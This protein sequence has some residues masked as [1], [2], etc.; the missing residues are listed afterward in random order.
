MM[1]Q[2]II[3]VIFFMALIILMIIACEQQPGEPD[4]INIFDPKNVHTGGDPFDLTAWIANGGVTLKWNRISAPDLLNYKIYRSEQESADL[5]EIAS[6]NPT[7]TLYID[8]SVTNGHSY[9]YRVTAVNSVGIETNRSKIAAVQIN[10]DPVLLINSGE[11]YS[12]THQVTLTILA[13]SAQ[14]MLLSNRYDFQDATWEEYSTEKTWQLETGEGEREVYLKIRY[15]DDAESSMISAQIIVDIT[16]PTLYIA[17]TP[18]SGIT[19]ETPFGFDPLLSSDNLT[20]RDD[21]HV[22]FDWENDGIWDESWKPVAIIYHIYTVGGGEKTVHIEFRDEAGWTV[23]T[24]MTLFINT[25]PEAVFKSMQDVNNL[26][27]FN[28]DCSASSDY[29]DGNNVTY[30]WDFDGDDMWDTGFI[31]DAST[32]H[33]YGTDGIYYAKL[34]VSDQQNLRSEYVIK[35]GSGMLMDIDG[36]FYKLV[37]IGNQHWILDNLK[38]TRYRN[39]E[40]IPEITLSM[41]WVGIKKG[42]YGNYYNEESNSET[43]GRLYNWHAVNDSRGLAPAGWHVPTD[44]EWKELEMYLGMSQSDADDII[45]R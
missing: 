45:L 31:T 24:T 25:R 44:A 39:G 1:R 13:A 14:Q 35:I 9:W 33:E 22:R 6:V 41:N 38:V 3:T 32:D 18:D 36:N 4:Y 42:A 19:N 27:L 7:D 5:E 21:L 8:Q 29:E 11:T 37:M 10:T 28:F 16:P 2:T 40:E 15:I 17:V 43:Y 34:E 30:R 23:D 20:P 26:R 12:H